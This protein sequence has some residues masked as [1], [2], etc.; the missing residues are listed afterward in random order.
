MQ[1]RKPQLAAETQPPDPARTGPSLLALLIRRIEKWLADDSV[2]ILWLAVLLFLGAPALTAWTVVTDYQETRASAEAAITNLARALEKDI[3]RNIEVYDLALQE[4]AAASRLPGLAEASPAL[5]RAALFSR[6]ATAEFISTLFVLDPAGNLVVD[7]SQPEIRPSNFAD[8]AYFRV[9]RDHPETGLYIDAPIHTRRSGTAVVIFSR[10]IAAD[11]G[12]FA[13]LV[14]AAVEIDYLSNLFASFELGQ[15]G[16]VSLVRTD[17]VILARY[18]APP[19]QIGSSLAGAAPFQTMLQQTTGVLEGLSSV[20]HIERTY[21][22]RRVGNLPLIVAV[23]YGRAAAFAAWRKK[24]LLTVTAIASLIGFGAILIAALRRQLVRRGVAERNTLASAEQARRSEANL[25]IAFDRIDAVFR[26]SADAQFAA[27][28][29]ADGQFAFDLINR[30][31]EDLTGLHADD[32][33]GRTPDECL[34]PETALIIRRNWDNCVANGEPLSYEHIRTVAI[35]PRHWETLLVPVRDVGGTIYRLIGT[36][37]DVTDRKQA[38]AELLQRNVTLEQRAATAAAAQHDALARASAAERLRILGQLASGIAHDFNN[39]LQSVTGCADIIERRAEE[40]N[41]MRHVARLI[42]DAAA[43]GTSITQRLLAFT[44]KDVT[45]F[46]RI[47]IATMLADVADMLRHTLRGAGHIE[48]RTAV[49]DPE[50]FVQIDPNELKTVLLNLATNA[51]DAMPDGGTITLGAAP[52]PGPPTLAPADYVRLWVHDDGHGMD[53]AT[54]A[55]ATEPFFTTKPAGQGT[56]LG[57][58]MARSYAEDGG[59]TLAI[60]SR[61]G[62]GTTVSLWLRR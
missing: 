40:P 60:A 39:V 36:I 51:R 29:R 31:C 48:I 56:G 28:R 53:D 32:V 33:V 21:A 59:G 54:I 52:D 50:L 4:T 15:G 46:E 41:T 14:A 55:R 11:D 9:P 61:P 43:R 6:V 45:Q 5:R 18:P 42:N 7:S 19:G 27:S 62:L 30:R 8:R 24:S 22:Y 37:R 34:P 16:S 47:A 25:A 26:H 2:V 58:S 17:G 20:D 10:R 49:D 57:L 12:S 44:R 13:G 3:A 38:E 23:S 35:G 1:S